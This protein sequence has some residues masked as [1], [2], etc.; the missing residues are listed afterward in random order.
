MICLLSKQSISVKISDHGISEDADMVVAGRDMVVT[1][2][3]DVTVITR[4]TLVVTH[5][6]TGTLL[7]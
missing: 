5:A 6:H 3:K 4:G 1:H 2:T 7:Q